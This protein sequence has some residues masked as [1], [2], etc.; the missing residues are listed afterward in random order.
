MQDKGET[1][2]KIPAILESPLHELKKTNMSL[3]PNYMLPGH[4]GTSSANTTFKEIDLPVIIFHQGDQ[5][6]FLA[7]WITFK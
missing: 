4:T 7:E 6:N 3:F 2:G 1:N 5:L